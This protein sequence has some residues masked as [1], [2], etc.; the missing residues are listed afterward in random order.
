MSR[1]FII[2]G[3]KASHGDTAIIGDQTFLIHG[4]LQKWQRLLKSNF[5]T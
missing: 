4:S 2:I 5:R 1:L 3:D